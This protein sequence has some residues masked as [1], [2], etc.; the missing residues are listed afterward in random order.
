KEKGLE[1]AISFNGNIVNYEELK[2]QFENLHQMPFTCSADTELILKMYSRALQAQFLEAKENT[3]GNKKNLGI[4]KD[5]KEDKPAN[6]A[7]NNAKFLP[8]INAMHNVML[9]L[10]GAYSILLLINDGTIVAVRDPK[11]FKPLSIGRKK[12]LVNDLTF[13]ASE[14]AALDALDAQF[15]RDIKPGEIAIINKNGIYSEQRFNE[16][17]AHC[18]FEWVYFSRPDSVIEER[19]VHDVRVRLGEEL[20]KLFKHEIDLVIP[21]P[22][23]GRSSALG[24]SKALGIPIEE[25]L[26]K[27]RYIH[28]TFI[29]PANEQRKALLKLKLNPIRSII[30]GKRIAIVDDSVIRG[31]T[32]K[33]LV[34]LLRENGA[35]EVHL[36]VSCPPVISP[37]YMGIDFPTYKELL[38]SDS[39]I[40]QIT[41]ELGADSVTYNTTEGLQRALA[42][43]ENDNCMA[44]LTG[45]YPTPKIHEYA[46]EMKRRGEKKS[47]TIAVLASGR[48]SNLQSIIDHIESKKLDARVGCVISDNFDSQALKRAEKHGIDFK[49]IDPGKYASKEEYEKEILKI[50]N[51]KQ[52]DLVVLAGYMRIVGKTLLD[53]FS[54]KIINIHPTLLP[55]FKGCAGMQCHEEVLKAG[56][57][58]S[59]ATAHIVTADVDGGP[60][61]GQRKV[62]VFE[63]DTPQKLADRVL[64]EEHLLLPEVIALFVKGKHGC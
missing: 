26:I 43:P 51:E 47:F 22:D 41:E 7:Q 45:V 9:K 57:K 39:N 40:A 54:G 32:M 12:T 63:S 50:L 10:V 2:S 3:K 28:R 30:Q 18:M 1:I 62:P 15:D 49:A 61:L 4:G 42:L 24:F 44:C 13:V 35:K 17:H 5:A 16:K 8:Y 21:I 38:A 11:G 64:K 36:L 14:T 29:M 31:N 27:N 58:E 55:K 46:V 34:K 20:A 23:S 37:C 33:R 59:G 56:E 60:I 19:P 53:A 25:G 6:P 52:T 48:G